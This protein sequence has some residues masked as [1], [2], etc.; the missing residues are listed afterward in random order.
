MIPNNRAF[1][2][3]ETFEENGKVPKYVQALYVNN[4]SWRIRK[5]V[6]YPYHLPKKEYDKAYKRVI[7]LMKKLDTEVILSLPYMNIFHQIYVMKL[8]GKKFDVEI[9]DGKYKVLCENDLVEESDS[10]KSTITKENSGVSSTRNLG[11]SKALGKYIL[12]LDSDD[13]LS[14]NAC[15]NLFN[16][17]EKHYDEIDLVTYPIV[18]DIHGR[19]VPHVR[20]DNM[21]YNGTGVYDLEVDYNLIQATVNVM[22]KNNFE[23]NVLFDV[24][25]NFYHK[26]HH[27]S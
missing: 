17:F 20:Y 16:L 24:D 26:N 21:Y 18:Y 13:Y 2:G 19:K 27:Q 4:I 25:Q 23:D 6:L 8:Q 5:D 10:V 11:M 15:K 22:V 9:V 7:N 12:F 14:Q 1:N 3:R